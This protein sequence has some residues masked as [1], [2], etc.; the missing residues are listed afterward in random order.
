MLMVEV[1]LILG[2]YG[3]ASGQ[4]LT[5]VED[6]KV[7]S[8]LPMERLLFL[9]KGYVL[10][11]DED[12]ANCTEDADGLE[13]RTLPQ[14]LALQVK[15]NLKD[16]GGGHYYYEDD[17][18]KNS[19]KNKIQTI[20]QLSVTSLAFLAFGGYLL[21]LLIHAIKGKQNNNVMTNAAMIKTFATYVATKIRD[22]KK[23]KTPN[24]RNKR[25][26]NLKLQKRPSASNQKRP[27]RTANKVNKN[28]QQKRPRPIKDSYIYAEIPRPINIRYKRDEGEYTAGGYLMTDETLYNALVDLSEVYSKFNTLDYVRYNKTRY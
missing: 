7:L 4:D 14:A 27:N 25:K 9:K 20:F 17:H 2:L 19:K 26:K 28:Q 11:K 23:K 8:E 18:E 3:F 1:P 12:C 24:P 15:T 21:C 16:R 5:F 13:S 22:V 6:V 10:G